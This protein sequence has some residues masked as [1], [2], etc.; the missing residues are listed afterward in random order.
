MILMTK[1]D[2]KAFVANET[3][4]DAIDTILEGMDNMLEEQKKVF[5]TKEDLKREVSYL[6]DDIRGL[7]GDRSLAS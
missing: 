1:K 2:P 6:R 4:D 5:A 7:E 3:L